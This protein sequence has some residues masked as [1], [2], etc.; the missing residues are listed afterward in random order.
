MSDCTPPNPNCDA[1]I[2]S[3]VTGDPCSPCFSSNPNDLFSLVKNLAAEVC[4]LNT[5]LNNMYQLM[6]RTRNR[7]T[8]VEDTL[9][10]LPL[11]EEVAMVGCGG[12]EAADTADAILACDAGA[13]K[14]F[15][16][17]SSNEVLVSCGGKWKKSPKG[18]SFYPLSAS[19]TIANGL[20]NS[21]DYPTTLTS[22]PTNTCGDVWAVLSSRGT[23]APGPSGSSTSYYAYAGNNVILQV[24]L[25]SSTESNM[26]FTKVSSASMPISVIK[27][28]VGQTHLIVDLIGYMY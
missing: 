27:T 13:E 9:N 19:S 3:P 28:G 11:E 24:G 25:A 22:F 5:R 2:G 23:T 4:A 18:L 26:V 14:A 20:V 7:L 17:T 15:T 16:A 8:S 1:P 12:L 21:G 6:G 10:N